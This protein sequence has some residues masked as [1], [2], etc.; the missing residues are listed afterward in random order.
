MEA[1][2]VLIIAVSG[3]WYCNT[4]PQH[5]QT[6]F[7]Y[8]G[9]HLYFRCAMYGLVLLFVAGLLHCAIL[10]ILKW[11]LW[12]FRLGYDYW[13]YLTALL[14]KHQLAP[15]D[16][17]Q[18]ASA[19]IILSLTMLSMACS[20]R[21]YYT[22]CLWVL[23]KKDGIKWDRRI[24]DLLTAQY[25]LIDSPLDTLLFEAMT[26]Q[27]PLMVS[28]DD[29]KVYIGRILQMGEPKSNKESNNQEILMLPLMS[30]Y[31][32]S[33]KLAVTITTNYENVVGEYPLILKQSKIVSATKF[34]RE[35]FKQFSAK[36][37]KKGSK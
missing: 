14:I 35:A 3:F 31:R 1:L 23:H 32:D 29:R 2:A 10:G 20:A 30:G 22:F 26:F 9:H 19:L 7:R 33:E 13:T 6:V 27:F 28:L 25:G 15:K 21:F 36:N 18:V 8:D 4:H 37:E 24:A 11:D 5:R 17:A 16:R 34:D 12:P